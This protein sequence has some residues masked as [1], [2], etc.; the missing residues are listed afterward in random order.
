LA[1]CSR[2]WNT[3]SL[4]CSRPRLDRG[5]SRWRLPTGRRARQCSTPRDASRQSTGCVA[6]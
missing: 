2:S 3:K 6:G 4:A 1:C 5:L